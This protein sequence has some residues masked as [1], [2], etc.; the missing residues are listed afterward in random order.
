MLKYHP[1]RFNLARTR[2]PRAHPA[3]HRLRPTVEVAEERWLLSSFTVNS[4]GDTGSGSGTSGDLRYCISQADEAAGSNITFSVAG[5]ILLGSA[6]PNLTQN[7]TITGP[8][9]ALLTVQGGGPSS[10]FASSPY[11]AGSR[12][13]FP[14]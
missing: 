6:L 12:R 2:S 11:T 3:S 8:G 1:L 10:N 14:P 7:I 9:A 5:T 13:R 4:L